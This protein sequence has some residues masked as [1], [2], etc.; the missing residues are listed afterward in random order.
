VRYVAAVTVLAFAGWAFYR[1]V[2]ICEAR[3]GLDQ[4]AKQ[5]QGNQGCWP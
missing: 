3:R 4:L 2:A 1:A 5:R